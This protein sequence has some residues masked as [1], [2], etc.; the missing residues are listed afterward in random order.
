MRLVSFN[1]RLGLDSSL[2]RIA[3]VIADLQPDVVC[4]QEVGRNWVMGERVPMHEV[5]GA[6][7]GMPHTLY[8]PAIHRGAAQYGIAVLSAH[9]LR[10]ELLERLPRQTD[11]PRVLVEVVVESPEPFLLMTSHVSVVD[12]DRPDQL[13]AIAERYK[14]RSDCGMPIVIAGD[15]NAELESPELAH[16]IEATGVRSALVEVM[17]DSPKTFPTSAP[18]TAIDHILISSDLEVIAASAFTVDASDH[19]PIAVDVARTRDE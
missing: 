1:I 19:L 17:G 14:V 2:A 18:D 6:A 4:L 11:E 3:E 13:R 5:I 9:P 16:L 7:A 12:G 15:L 8:A 10:L